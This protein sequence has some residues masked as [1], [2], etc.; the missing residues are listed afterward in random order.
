M[1]SPVAICN[2]ALA[3]VGANTILSLDD[4]Q[5]EAIV[6]KAVYNIIRDQVLEQRAWTFATGRKILSPLAEAPEFG[7][8][9]QYL[10][11]STVI[12]LLGVDEY[13]QNSVGGEGRLYWVREGDKILCD[14]S[15]IR[16]R[17]I[18]KVDDSNQWSPAFVDAFSYAMAAEIAMPIAHSRTMAEYYQTLYEIKISRASATDGGQ[19]RQEKIRSDQ[20]IRRR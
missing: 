3:L 16:V 14:V 5:T 7:F 9:F 4:D 8:A 20:L 1:S 6:C 19:G 17:W 2:K 11:P 12:R 18:S 13:N 10:I 15:Q